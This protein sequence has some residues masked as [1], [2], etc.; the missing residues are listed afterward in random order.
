MPSTFTD[1]LNYRHNCLVCHPVNPPYFVPLVEIV[2]AEWTSSDA[3]MK[4]RNLMQQVGQ[5][6]V[7][8]R[9]EVPGFAVNRVQ[10]AILN[11]C[12]NLVKSNTISP[13]DIDTGKNGHWT[14]SMYFTSKR[15]PKE[16]LTSC[17]KVLKLSTHFLFVLHSDV[18]RTGNALC[19]PRSVRGDPLECEWLPR[20]R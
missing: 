16:F 3:A 13:E 6:P 18:R 12:F 4:V 10:Y 15:I 20:L 7:N 8:L 1:S 11:E 19:F 17:K 14:I 9:Q 2:P 5:K